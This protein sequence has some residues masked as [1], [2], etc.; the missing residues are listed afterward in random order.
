M[1]FFLHFTC[2][3]YFCILSF[4]LLRKFAILVESCQQAAKP[5]LWDNLCKNLPFLE[6]RNGF[7]WVSYPYA[8]DGAIFIML[9][10]HAFTL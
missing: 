9:G 4:I 2:S 8:T 1:V 6:L 3:L 10:Y 7:W 5:L